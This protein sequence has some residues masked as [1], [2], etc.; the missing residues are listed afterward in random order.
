MRC[1][2]VMKRI[3]QLAGLPTETDCDRIQKLFKFVSFFY[4][5]RFSSQ[6]CH[7]KRERSR[8]YV[9]DEKGKN[10]R[11]DAVRKK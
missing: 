4:Y 8:S 6:F 11:K 5:S 9:T 3:L 10:G 1:L 7:L 2:K